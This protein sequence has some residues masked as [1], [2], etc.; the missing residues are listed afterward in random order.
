GTGLGLAIS[1]RIVKNHGGTLSVRSKPDEGATFIIRL[2]AP[3]AETSA[4]SEPGLTEGT[5]FPT[6]RPS[7]TPPPDNTPPTL[8]PEGKGRRE[9]KRRAV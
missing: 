6:A 1:Q 8:R 2:P 5:S 9:K 3:P 7:D 4:S